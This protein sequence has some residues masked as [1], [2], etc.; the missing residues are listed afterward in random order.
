MNLKVLAATSTAAVSLLAVPSSAAT[1][2]QIAYQVVNVRSMPTTASNVSYKAT[3]GTKV[4]ILSYKNGWY[5]VSINGRKGWVIA[6]AVNFKK[7]STNTNTNN[8][9]NNNTNTV[10]TGVSPKNYGAYVNVASLN[11]RTGP[12]TSYSSMGRL[13]YKQYVRVIGQ[14][15]GWSKIQANGRTGYVASSYLTTSAP[16]TNTKNT[17][18]S[19]SP[20]STSS[21]SYGAYVN[22]SALNYRSGPSTSSLS[23]GKLGYKQYV[24]VLS[25]S[26]G[27][28]KIQANGRTGYVASSY[29][30]TSA[31]KNNTVLNTNTTPK[32]NTSYY[33]IVNTPVLNVRSSSSTSSSKI[34]R[35]VQGQ[36]VLVTGTVS[37]WNKINANGLV[38]YVA[39]AYLTNNTS[40]SNVSNNTYQPSGTTRYVN[41]GMSLDAFIEKQ[42]K[43]LNTTSNGYGWTNASKSQIKAYADPNSS[44]NKNSNYQFAKLNTYTPDLTVEQV[45]SYLNKYCGPGNVFHNKGQA[46]INAA[47]KYN[48][49]VLYFISHSMIETGYGK[50]S[51]AKGSYYNG[52]KV[53]NFYGIG[54]YDGNAYMGGKQTAYKNGWTSV[55]NGLYG[56][57]NWISANYIHNKTY[58]QDT[59]YKMRWDNKHQYHQYATDVSWARTIGEKMKNIASYA[60]KI[61]KISYE[62][63]VYR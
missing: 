39:S 10:N 1:Q 51:L 13:T 60:K 21:K 52:A 62:K 29:L 36:R 18:S 49:N 55:D 45:N 32:S 7:I 40:S 15:G 8:N 50:S 46:F 44:L 11:Y 2:A 28:S 22:V 19:S 27:W 26:G 14:S 61:L 41:Q 63:P 59:L 16:S 43:K 38:G 25:Q 33:M 12:S 23:Y 35:V 5:Q 47:K 6:S 24:T 34:G 57:A 30:T 37:G 58:Q 17:A 31:T 9:T 53:Y 20:I 4:A 42:A 56:A 54:A 48:I 3:L